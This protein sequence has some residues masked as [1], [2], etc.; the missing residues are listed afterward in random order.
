MPTRRTTYKWLCDHC[1]LVCD[2]EPECAVHE[3]TAHQSSANDVHKLDDICKRMQSDNRTMLEKYEHCAYAILTRAIEMKRALDDEAPKCAKV[4][5]TEEVRTV[6]PFNFE[7][8]RK[9]DG[10]DEGIEEVDTELQNEPVR[11]DENAVH[12]KE[13]GKSIVDEAPKRLQCSECTE[14]FSTDIHLRSHVVTEHD[15]DNI[16]PTS[17]QLQR[18]FECV[19]CN[20]TFAKK[21][22]LARFKYWGYCILLY[23]LATRSADVALAFRA[24]RLV[25]IES[26]DQSACS[27]RKRY[28]LW[29]DSGR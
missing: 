19:T 13:Y 8:P 27:H 26:R 25:E 11:I 3:R 24:F 23:T 6:S 5:E 9:S 29:T 1:S 10:D 20:K 7:L 4:K 18:K 21:Q 15:R 14:S 22:H 2:T 28:V 17:S 16:K 12:D